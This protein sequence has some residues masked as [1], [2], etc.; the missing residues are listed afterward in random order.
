MTAR[1]CLTAWWGGTS[2]QNPA[3]ITFN[4]EALW[5]NGRAIDAANLGFLRAAS[6]LSWYPDLRHL[7]P[8]PGR[9]RQ[10]RESPG[11]QTSETHPSPGVG[12][13]ADARARS[14]PPPR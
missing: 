2:C 11:F 7:D 4:T 13:R 5:F 8:A 9:L 1:V 12:Q 3:L 10:Q 14:L 6:T